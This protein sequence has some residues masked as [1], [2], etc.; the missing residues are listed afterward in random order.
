MQFEIIKGNIVNASTDAIVLPANPKLMEGPGASAAI[1]DAAGRKKLAKACKEVL[2]ENGGSCEVGSAIPTLAFG[3]NDNGTK[4]VI[5]AIVPKWIDG[6]HQEYDN[7][8]SAYLTSLKI[9][10]LMDCTSIAFPLLASGNNG[11]DMSLALEIADR[12]FKDFESSIL[13][14]IVLV[15]HGDNT[16]AFVKEK[17]YEYQIE[18]PDFIAKEKRNLQH[19][20]KEQAK[21]KRVLFHDMKDTAQSVIEEQ[22]KKALEYLKNPD[23]QKALL[24]KAVQIVA[25]AKLIIKKAP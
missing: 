21:H 22:L 16:A 25:L 1:F 13:Q 20:Q 17:G 7:L 2:K 23:N 12:S 4:F 15:I 14:K 5:H 9:A 19:E 3:L 11:F 18:I 10:E 24:E 6:E 8:C